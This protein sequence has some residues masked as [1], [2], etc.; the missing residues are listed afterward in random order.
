M[1]NYKHQVDGLIVRTEEVRGT[2]KYTDDGGKEKSVPTARSV[3]DLRCPGCV[4]DHEVAAWMQPALCDPSDKASV[5]CGKCGGERPVIEHEKSLLAGSSWRENGQDG[6]G[7]VFYSGNSLSGWEPLYACVVA[8]PD[9]PELRHPDC[10]DRD[11]RIIVPIARWEPSKLPGVQSG[12]TYKEDMQ[13]AHKRE[14]LKARLCR[15]CHKLTEVTEFSDHEYSDDDYDKVYEL[16]EDDPED[17]NLT[18]RTDELLGRKNGLLALMTN[19]LQYADGFGGDLACAALA[20]VLDGEYPP[21]EG[22]RRIGVPE[23]SA[24]GYQAAFILDRF[25]EENPDLIQ[26]KGRF[27]AEQIDDAIA[28]LRDNDY[29]ADE[30]EG[31]MQRL[32]KLWN[33]R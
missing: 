28:E 25:R 15:R 22:H 14:F 19:V 27:S 24:A 26:T 9:G 7:Q 16:P 30:E 6:Y 23:T 32:M 17:R 4:D 21:E 5:T 3:Y 20:V 1:S 29:A 8:T 31:L 10:I 12:F 11:E 13:E 18:A 2:F 33:N